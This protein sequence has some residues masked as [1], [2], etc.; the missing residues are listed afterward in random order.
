MAL[1]SKGTIDA[2]Y[3]MLAALGVGLGITIDYILF[4]YAFFVFPYL[5][6]A[7]LIAWIFF[8]VFLLYIIFVRGP[9]SAQ[10]I[11]VHTDFLELRYFGLFKY[12]RVHPADI[13]HFGRVKKKNIEYILIRTSRYE[14]LLKEKFVQNSEELIDQLKQWR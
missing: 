7:F 14:V 1:L 6:I 2:G 8:S 13:S 5:Q 3:V 10:T 12:A 4:R 11:D 9:K